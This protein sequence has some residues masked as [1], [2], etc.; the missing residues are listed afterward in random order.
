MFFTLSFRHPPSPAS[1]S[2]TLFLNARATHHGSAVQEQSTGE[3]I[4]YKTTDDKTSR[5]RTTR[6]NEQD[7]TKTRRQ[8]TTGNTN[9]TRTKQNN[10]EQT[11]K[12][13]G[14]KTVQA[15]NVDLLLGNLRD[16]LKTLLYRVLLDDPQRLVLLQRLAGDVKGQVPGGS[17]ARQIRKLVRS[18]R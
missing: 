12:K 14:A 10:K 2:H 18:G 6:R 11:D 17:V 4:R 9:D 1:S 16:H 15:L 8:T 3:A 7:K 13:R 5:R